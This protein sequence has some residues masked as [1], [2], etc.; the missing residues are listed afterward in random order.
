MFAKC[1]FNS[2]DRAMLLE[3]A[4]WVWSVFFPSVKF[5]KFDLHQHMFA[6]YILN[7]QCSLGLKCFF[8]KRWMFAT[9]KHPSTQASNNKF[10]KFDLHQPLLCL[11]SIFSILNAPWVWSVFSGSVE[12]LH[13][14]SICQ[15]K[16]LSSIFQHKH[17]SHNCQKISWCSSKIG[18]L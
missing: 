4:P 13:P 3:N 10:D 14:S 7:S 2:V 15:H 17:H 8:R 6:K 1:I 11:P 9:F 18:S 5:D 16:Y 12:C